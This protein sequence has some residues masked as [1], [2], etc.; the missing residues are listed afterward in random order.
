MNRDVKK[1]I[2]EV[3]ADVLA[4]H[5]FE[6]NGTISKDL[7]LSYAKKLSEFAEF[8]ATQIGVKCVFSVVDAVGD[9]MLL[10]R[11]NDSL[12]ISIELAQNKAFTAEELRM[13]TEELAKISVPG[14]SLYSIDNCYGGRITLIPGGFPLF[15]DGKVVGAIGVS[16]GTAE[17]DCEIARYVLDNL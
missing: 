5:D 7:D 15:K 10:H 9:T 2:E 16:G 13:S 12:R 3:V 6:I 11:M 4:K 8:K 1:I 14:E 17:E